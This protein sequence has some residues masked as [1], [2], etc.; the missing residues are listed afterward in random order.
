MPCQSL[1]AVPNRLSQ[2]KR[3]ARIAVVTANIGNIRERA[4]RLDSADLE[5]YMAHIPFHRSTGGAFV[6]ASVLPLAAGNG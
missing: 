4:A 2:A 5:S 1:R 6:R 3:A